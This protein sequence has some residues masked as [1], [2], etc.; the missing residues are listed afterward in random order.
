MSSIDGAPVR[1]L[2]VCV[3]RHCGNCS[4]D[5][6]QGRSQCYKPL[7]VTPHHEY[8]PVTLHHDIAVIKL[9]KS[10]LC[11][12]NSAIP[13]CLPNRT[14]NQSPI[15]TRPLMPA[16]LTGWGNDS[17]SSRS[18]CL[19]KSNVRLITPYRGC[20]LSYLTYRA[21][22]S[23]TD[24][25]CVGDTGAPLVFK[26]TGIDEEARYFLVAIVSW[27]WGKGYGTARETGVYTSVLSHLDWVNRLCTN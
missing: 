3:G 12:C 5:D 27:P 22:G 13:V 20:K 4:R 23:S 6:S 21:D 1:N 15:T 24:G 17:I 10:V 16:L 8:D 14:E 25:S 9:R 2:T 26:S 7:I 19:R 11:S 18:G